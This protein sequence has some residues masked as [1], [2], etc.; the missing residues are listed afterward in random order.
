M[1]IRKVITT[2]ICFSLIAV[3][4]F[5]DGVFAGRSSFLG[6]KDLASVLPHDYKSLDLIDVSR[7]IAKRHVFMTREF[8]SA[9]FCA[10]SVFHRAHTIE[11]I[12]IDTGF[13]YGADCILS[14]AVKYFKE[15]LSRQYYVAD[16]SSNNIEHKY[17]NTEVSG[18]LLYVRALRRS[19]LPA[20]D[21]SVL[22]NKIFIM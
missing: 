5:P 22:M 21:N 11:N 7:K 4:S 16:I 3:F 8:F 13:R 9:A 19:S 10:V 12:P 15:R 6:G 2:V 17:K 18:Y 1:K 14:G 20:P